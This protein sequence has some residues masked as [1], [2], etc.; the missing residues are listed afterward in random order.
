MWN[1]KSSEEFSLYPTSP[2]I[3]VVL[4]LYL[5]LLCMGKSGK[6]NPKKDLEEMGKLGNGLKICC[7]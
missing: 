1:H 7:W 4:L 6:L 2:V 5:D 3:S